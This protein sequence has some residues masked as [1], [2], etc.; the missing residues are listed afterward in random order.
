LVSQKILQS[1]YHKTDEFIRED[2]VK[3]LLIIGLFGF[4]F[5][6]SWLIQETA[7]LFGLSLNL[8]AKSGAGQ[9]ALYSV[10][11]LSVYLFTRY[12]WKRPLGPPF[13]LYW[14]NCRVALRG[15][16]IFY[17]IAAASV[18]ALYI[19]CLLV[20][21]A[22]WTGKFWTRLTLPNGMSIAFGFLASLV[23]AASEEL[24]FRGF[25]F[26]Y[27]LG[28]GGKWV[29]ASAVVVS[30][31]LFA[32]VHNFRDPLVWLTIDELPLLIGLTLLGIVLALT[33][34]ATGNLACSVG[35]HGGLLAVHDVILERTSAI[36][37]V[38][39]SWWMGSDNDIRTASI[40][41]LFLA[42]LAVT[43]WYFGPWFRQRYKVETLV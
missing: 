39:S 1:C 5:V 7:P 6:V 41:W 23:V 34:L 17:G 22:E 36:A 21:S 26:R 15:L 25:S 38:Q 12:I 20:G 14:I 10:G 28:N 4:V 29:T 32:L 30:A 16:V 37:L 18:I 24:I 40:A 31:L 8:L 13:Q 2:L 42:L 9:I 43:I 33:Y 19:V 11:L 35:L 27:L 3:L